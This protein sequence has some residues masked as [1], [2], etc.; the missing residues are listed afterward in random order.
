MTD[1]E[2]DRK[3]FSING[4]CPILALKFDSANRSDGRK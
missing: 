2:G 1:R 4:L 3:S